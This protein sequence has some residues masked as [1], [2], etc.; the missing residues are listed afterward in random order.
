MA[1][2]FYLDSLGCKVNSYEV[3][4]FREPLRKL[5]MEET[6]SPEEADYIILNG[7]AVTARSVQK[8]RQR[9]R[10]LRRL[11]PR[12]KIL[13]MGCLVASAPGLATSLGADYEIGAKGRNEA[14]GLLLGE[15]NMPAAAGKR[16]YEEPLNA[17]EQ[18]GLRGYLKV[19]DGC[20]RFCAYCLIPFLR[21]P[22]CSRKREDCLAEARE[23]AKIHPEIVVTGIEV[24][25]YGK[26]L[27]DGNYRLPD[28]L[29][30]ILAECPGLRRLRLSSLE[31]GAVDDKMLELLRREPRLCSHV[32]LSL[33]SG[34]DR[35]LKA[36]GRPYDRKRF[37]EVVSSLREARPGIAITTDVIVGFPG[38]SEKDFEDSLA[39]CKEVGFAEIHAFPYSAR[40]GTRAASMPSQVDPAAKKERERR[41]LSLSKELRSRFEAANFGKKKEVLLESYDPKS[42]TWTGH[43]SDYLLVRV[44]DEGY[45]RG[46]AVEAICSPENMAD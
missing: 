43:T 16:G 21:G 30:D 22:S 13:A 40:K 28:L 11:A 10:K 36:M 5:G 7:C 45:G 2:R 35:I 29:R 17:S 12:A 32:H 46:E 37:L 44:K 25:F 41:M 19:Q 20:S 38:E 34:S 1:K 39:F 42:R 6:D 18:E 4:L 9:I 27:G 23:L 8:G 33:Q 26:D 31:E 24:A 3:S 15:G 14:L